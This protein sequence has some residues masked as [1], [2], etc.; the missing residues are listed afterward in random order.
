MRV[1]IEGYHINTNMTG[2]RCFSKILRPCA[3]DRISRQQHK[4]LGFEDFL[5]FMFITLK[6]GPEGFVLLTDID[7]Y[8]SL[9]KGVGSAALQREM[10]LAMGRF[11]KQHLTSQPHHFYRRGISYS[12]LTRYWMLLNSCQSGININ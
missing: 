12:R 9:S 7:A 3:L 1:L 5:G 10:Y 6:C 2:F 4:G 8:F 11:W